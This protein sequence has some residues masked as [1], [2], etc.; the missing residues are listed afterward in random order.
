VVLGLARA[1]AA[2]GGVPRT[3]VFAFFG[4]EELGLRGSSH[5]VGQPAWP[6]A[7]TVAM[8]NFDM[9][10][11]LRDGRL[12]VGGVD[13][14]SSLRRLVEEAARAEGVPVELTSSPFSASDHT[15]F[16]GAGTPVL[17]FFT[18]LHADYH[19]P[20]DTADRTDAAGMARVA[21]LAARVVDELAA[22]TPP[23]YVKLAPPSWRGGQAARVAAPVFLGVAFDGRRG[24]DGVPLSHVVPDS[25]A[26]RAGLREGDVLVRL[27]DAAVDTFD[28]LRAV[29]GR[30]R[31][32]DQ[33]RIV[34]LRDGVAQ[35]ATTT[36]DAPAR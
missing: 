29:L 11:R 34:Y 10:G 26:A 16:Y 4:A 23:A 22:A 15:R 18:G 1:F 20:T 5:Y 33:V 12:Q 31:P 19:R 21:A 13:S 3:L 32:G 8:L 36:L 25:A 28:D 24:W 9:V 17:F 2:A 27:G 30:A 35:T 6:L 14:G 7:R